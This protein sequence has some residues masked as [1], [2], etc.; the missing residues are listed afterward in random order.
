MLKEITDNLLNRLPDNQSIAIFRLEELDNSLFSNYQRYDFYQLIWFTKAEGNTSY[1]LDF[2]E[3]TLK[4]NH[5]V[6]VFPGQID[7]LETEGK[8][9]FLFAINNES[10]FRINQRINSDYLNGYFSNA[11]LLPDENT[12]SILNQ[13]TGLIV[14]EYSSQNRAILMEA[15]MEAFLFHISS[16]H[17]TTAKSNQKSDFIVSKL[18]NLIDTHFISERDTH[19]YAKALDLTP[20]KMNEDCKKGTGKTVKQHLQE[21]L[22]LEVKKEIRLNRKSLK[23]IA[24]DLGFKETAYFTRFF[25]QHTGITPTEFRNQ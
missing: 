7:M 3:H 19:F 6:L 13:L 4:S 20:K 15:Y 22:I 24:F 1:F 9:G 18:M 8:E 5:I 25:K 2:N 17:D 23:E 21:R 16:L 12:I 14:A 10:L 11:F